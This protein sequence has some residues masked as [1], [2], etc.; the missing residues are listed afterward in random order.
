MIKITISKEKTK[1][2]DAWVW[3]IIKGLHSLPISTEEETNSLWGR[4]GYVLC[5]FQ[6]R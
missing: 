1:R 2:V 4:F 6:N 5:P 3:V